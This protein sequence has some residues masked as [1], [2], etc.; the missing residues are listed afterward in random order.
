MMRNLSVLF[1]RKQNK[2]SRYRAR[3]TSAAS[4]R[5]KN[6]K[7]T[8]NSHAAASRTFPANRGEKHG[9]SKQMQQV[10]FECRHRQQGG[11]QKLP[12]PFQLQRQNSA[13][14]T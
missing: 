9:A 8:E 11:K 4:S 1:L 3:T 7:R 10:E 6:R 2:T 14:K 13:A 12:A 5:K